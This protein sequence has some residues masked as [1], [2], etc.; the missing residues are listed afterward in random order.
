MRVL[1][2]THTLMWLVTEAP[3]PRVPSAALGVL[4]DPVNDLLVSAITPWEMSI[5][6][7]LGKLPEAG[8]ILSTWSTMIERLRATIVPLTDEHAIL[9]GGLDWPHNDPFDRALAAQA[10][11]EGA[12]LVSAD[13]AFDGLPGVRRIW[14]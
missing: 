2:D 14:A 3:T 12:V 9:A 1:A 13:A 7:R 4:R 5:K 8:P 10:M 6:F 11:I